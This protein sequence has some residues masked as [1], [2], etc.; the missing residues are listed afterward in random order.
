MVLD[1]GGITGNR[2]SM[3]GIELKITQ[4]VFPI[5]SFVSLYVISDG[6]NVTCIYFLN[7]FY[8]K[9]LWLWRWLFH[10]LLFLSVLASFSLA[11]VLMH[12]SL[13]HIS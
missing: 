6:S 11:N 1:A 10:Q 8:F 5:L 2:Y 9:L 3:S 12:N 4:P 13:I 7:I